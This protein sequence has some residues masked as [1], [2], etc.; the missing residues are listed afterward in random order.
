MLREVEGLSYKE[1]SEVVNVPVGTI[2]SRLS[3]ARK[4]LQEALI[5]SEQ[6]P[7]I[8]THPD[9]EAQVDMY[10]DG[11]LAGSDAGELE[12]HLAGCQTCGRLRD[13]RL[14]LRRAIAAELPRLDAPDALRERV[15]AT[16]R[17]RVSAAGPP[18]RPGRGVALAGPRRERSPSSRS[19]AGGSARRT[20]RRL[21]S[22]T[23]CWRVTCA[24]SCRAT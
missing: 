8:M 6:G 17:E 4:R 12:A 7:W 5:L 21:S 19:A 2:M 9:M 22:P 15:R 10:L 23:R 24:R 13:D 1:M 18:L 20:R 14:A 3:R 11:E 16:L